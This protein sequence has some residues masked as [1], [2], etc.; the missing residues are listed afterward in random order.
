[1][2]ALASGFGPTLLTRRSGSTLCLPIFTAT[3]DFRSRIGDASLSDLSGKYRPVAIG[4]DSETMSG[5]VTLTVTTEMRSSP[6]C[7]RKDHAASYHQVL[8]S[9]DLGGGG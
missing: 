7:P 3:V 1:M 6:Q 2:R 5:E 9:P 8:V 4:S